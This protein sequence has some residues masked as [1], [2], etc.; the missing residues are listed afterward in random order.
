MTQRS[1][2]SKVGDRLTLTCSCVA[3]VV[4]PIILML[5]RHHVVRILAR[6]EHCRR[7]HHTR[8]CRV[9]VHWRHRG[10]RRMYTDVDDV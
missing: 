4:V 1:V 10:N 3:E 8:G 9:V 7:L 2:L 6:G 5:P